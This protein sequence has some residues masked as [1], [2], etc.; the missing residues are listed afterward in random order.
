MRLSRLCATLLMV[1]APITARADSDPV[2]Q[3]LTG[4]ENEAHALSTN[5]PDPNRLTAEAGQ[6][7]VVDAEV[8][9]ALGDYDKAAL[10]L[11]DI[12]S[13]Q[14]SQD[15][16]AATYYLAESLYQKGDQGAAHMY[17]DQLAQSNNA[18]S[19]YYQ[20]ALQRLVEIAIKNRDLDASSYVATLGG[21]S[22]AQRSP[23]VPY[24]LGKYAFSQDKYDDA[25]AQFAQV[26]KGSDYELQALYYTGTTYVAKKDINKAIDVFSDLI[27]R[28]PRT[29]IDRHSSR[30]TPKTTRR[31]SGAVAL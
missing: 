12:V 14:Q 7:R 26:P 3:K 24:V 1:L 23:A 9:F 13:K 22:P 6:K 11:F 20:P 5:L 19:K 21:L 30:S 31:N 18:S 8:A 4:F 15:L 16:D 25:I 17:F 29:A 28:K 10:I 27:V 2:S